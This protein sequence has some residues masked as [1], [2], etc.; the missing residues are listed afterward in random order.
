[1]SGQLGSPWVPVGPHG[2]KGELD[3]GRNLAA[4]AGVG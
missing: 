2:A 3:L 4:P 1:M